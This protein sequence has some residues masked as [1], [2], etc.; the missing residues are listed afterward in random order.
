MTKYRRFQGSFSFQRGTAS[1]WLCDHRV[2]FPI[3]LQAILSLT[4]TQCTVD[5]LV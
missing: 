2:C 3:L 4:S 1:F 5:S